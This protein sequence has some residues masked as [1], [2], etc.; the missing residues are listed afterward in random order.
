MSAFKKLYEDLT[1]NYADRYAAGIAN[2]EIKANPIRLTDI[3]NV[4]NQHPNNTEDN[5]AIPYELTNLSDVIGDLSLS[6][7]NLLYKLNSAM[8]SKIVKNKHIIKSCI[9]FAK[10]INK[11]ILK[12]V[13]RLKK[14][15]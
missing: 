6:N 13:D 11:C 14:A 4:N 1:M 5:S 15:N 12:I 7:D 8:D 9:F 3:F 10:I 2:R